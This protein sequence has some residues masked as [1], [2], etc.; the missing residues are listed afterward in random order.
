MAAHV[1]EAKKQVVND[2]VGLINEYPLIAAVNMENLPGKQLQN[3][4]EQLRGKV[5]IRMTK[6]RVLNKAFEAAEK[7]KPGISKLSEHLRGMPA[8]LFTKDN[9]FSL[10]KTLKK[11]QSN[12]PI[13]A[14]QTAPND[15]VVPAG[16]TG[17]APGPIIGELGGF[18]I[19]SG[20]ENGKVVVKA[21]SVV[22]K[23]GDIVSSE[24]AGVLTR[25]G[26][27]PMKVGLDLIAAFEDG[28]IVGRDVLDIDEEAYKNNI[29]LAATQA[30]NLSFNAAI[31]TTDTISM[32]LS[33]AAADALALALD[34]DILTDAT[35]KR[36]IGKAGTHAA[37]LKA[38]VPDAPITEKPVAKEES[39]PENAENVE[40][41]EAEAV[42]EEAGSAEVN[43]TETPADAGSAKSEETTEEAKPD[44]QSSE[45]K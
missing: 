42:P 6:R 2:F 24:L 3:M 16:P 27:E 29:I 15:L 45:E 5:V 18:G 28:E 10:F 38:M 41:K 37:T 23:A 21:D 35:A 1:S 30:T 44:T 4:R 40:E 19:K 31:P 36:T 22:A 26:I 32:L 7:Q 9:P 17:F 25:L 43:P 11:N 13:K 33:T 12:A 8:L 20:I 14:G 34:R 39:V